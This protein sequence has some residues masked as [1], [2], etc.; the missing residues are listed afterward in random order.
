MITKEEIE[1]TRSP[2]GLRQFVRRRI[3][4]VLKIKNER[5]KALRRHG[6]YKVFTDEI[7]P[8]SLTALKLYPNTYTVTPVIGNQGYDA[9]IKDNRGCIVDY[10][11]ITCP[12]DGKRKSD[13]ALKIV[14]RGYGNIDVY[15][16]GEDVDRL[17][18]FI[19]ETCQKKAQKDYSNCTLVV[20]IDF[21]RP[22]RQ[23]C[24]LY[25]RKLNQV[26]DQINPISFKAR[27]VFLLIM[28]FRKAYEIYG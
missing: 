1:K 27:R 15:S 13:D 17:C 10:V 2:R 21:V 14:T 9:I 12:Q 6:L 20:A 19:L 16:P 28:P 7:I 25:L 3:E 26:A 5:H 18:S 24:R 22:F 23:H 8:L 11:E 4:T